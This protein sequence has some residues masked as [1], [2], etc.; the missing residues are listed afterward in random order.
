MFLV[1]VILLIRP[2]NNRSGVMWWIK[3]VEKLEIEAQEPE[4]KHEKGMRKDNVEL[5]PY[6]F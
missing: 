6:G 1:E 2:R 3:T 5:I 4:Q